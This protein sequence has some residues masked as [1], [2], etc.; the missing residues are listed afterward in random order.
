MV[1]GNRKILI[2]ISRVTV[3]LDGINITG[4]NDKEHLG[5]LKSVLKRLHEHDLKIN[6]RKS[7][8][9]QDQIE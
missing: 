6:V 7:C 3:F 1:E 5:R 2:G 4:A 9:F 8:F